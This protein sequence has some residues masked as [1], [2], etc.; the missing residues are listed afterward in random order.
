MFLK[1]TSI[2][3]FMNV[4]ALCSVG[5][6]AT[7]FAAAADGA[8]ADTGELAEVVVTGSLIARKDFAA[9]SPILTV[10]DEVLKNSG[11]PQLEETVNY[12]PQFSDA[13]TGQSRQVNGSAPGAGRTTTNLR[14]LGTSRT[15]VLL[16]GRRLQPSDSFN[17][18]DLNLVPTALLDSVEVIT[19]GASAV[20]GS[21]AVAG[22][23]NF[24]TKS[25]FSGLQVDV[26][27]G[28]SALGDATY[29]NLSALVGRN[30]SNPKNNAVLS[31]SYYNRQQ[32]RLGPRDWFTPSNIVSRGPD[33]QVTGAGFTQASLNSLFMTKYGLSRAPGTAEVFSVN[34]DGSLYT[35][36]AGSPSN[37]GPSNC[38]PHAGLGGNAQ[39]I[40]N[41]YLTPNEC[42]GTSNN[43]A[44]L[45]LKRL[46]VFG[47][48]NHFMTDN[49]EV[50]GQMLVFDST[51]S[52]TQAGANIQHSAFLVSPSNVTIPADLRTLLAA[53]AN[54]NA[55]F[56]YSVRTNKV[57]EQ[58]FEQTSMTWQALAGVRGRL[59]LGDWTWDVNAASGKTK[60]KQ[61]ASNYI[62]IQAFAQLLIAADAGNSLCSGGWDLFNSQAPLSDA[63]RRYVARDVT[64]RDEFKQDVVQ[65][66]F[67]GALFK[68]WAGEVRAAAG[69]DVRKNS[70]STVPDFQLQTLQLI[71]GG[72]SQTAPILPGS[73]SQRVTEGFVEA[74]V[75]LVHDKPLLSDL[76]ADVAFRRSSYDTS[77]GANTWKGSLLWNVNPYIL[78]RGSKQRAI[79]AASV[80]ELFTGQTTALAQLGAVTTGGGDPCA[81]NHPA[82]TSANAAQIQAL[83][84]AQGVPAALYTTFAPT[85]TSFIA[86]SAGNPNL[87]PEQAD[88]TTYGIVFQPKFLPSTLR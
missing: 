6:A 81:F 12:M 16:D 51:T 73:G 24:K 46:T 52:Q 83:C 58:R 9:E 64:S 71:S 4:V 25:N 59:G 80:G 37:A 33:G 26:D 76:S 5:V 18:I 86:V 70:Y 32:A 10:N 27:T 19:G 53:R 2:R 41:P 63:C 35:Q 55:T 50:Y 17:V 87:K 8:A 69:A 82:R 29:G 39:Y 68:T 14:G 66:Q 75:P 77:G 84:L 45:P 56:T 88:S 57:G 23:V 48:A 49:T 13:S 74:L 40:F 3:R 85:G 7:P 43:N 60:A 11:T 72:V 65:A 30:F 44:L 1:F 34:P 31:V 36:G 22:V 61:F 62:N 47:K 15:L 28:R 21:D 38:K 20:Y 54:P 67:Q 79:R 78:V 42:D